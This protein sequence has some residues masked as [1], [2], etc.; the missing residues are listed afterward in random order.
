MDVVNDHVPYREPGELAHRTDSLRLMGFSNSKRY[1]ART[2]RSTVISRTLKR[3][4][5][6]HSGYPDGL[7]ASRWRSL[8]GTT[9]S[10]HT[11]RGI[12]PWFNDDQP[13][14]WWSP[15]PRAVILSRHELS[16]VTSRLASQRTP[17]WRLGEYSVNCLL[18]VTL[19]V[20][21]AEVIADEYGTWLT[22]KTCI[23]AYN[24]AP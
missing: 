7:L 10:M 17:R 8:T 12:F 22:A 6:L 5:A 14:L 20:H 9:D 13:I 11:R 21:C 1:P 16:P 18:A 4:L 23:A 15:D 24:R 19:F 2:I 3:W